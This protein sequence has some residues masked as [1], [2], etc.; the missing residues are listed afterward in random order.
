MSYKLIKVPSEIKQDN[1]QMTQIDAKN[2]FEWFN[3][4]KKE[5]TNI[6]NQDIKDHLLDIAKLDDIQL[7]IKKKIKARKKTPEEIY[8]ERETLPP[9]IKDSH[10]VKKYEFI[11]P[12]R[13]VLFD[14]SILLGDLLVSEVKGVSWSYEKD[15]DIVHFAYPVLIKDDVSMNFCPLWTLEMLSIK[16]HENRV[17]SDRLQ[18]IYDNQKNTFIGKPKDYESMINSWLK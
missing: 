16:I 14:V 12:T 7:Y 3:K 10:K 5:R 4:V 1:S 11:E 18:Y 6:L 17:K 15:E 8:I 9:S 13:S 2:Y